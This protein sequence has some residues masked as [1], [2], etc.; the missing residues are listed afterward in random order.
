MASSHARDV[1]D[2]CTGCSLIPGSFCNLSVAARTALSA[3]KFTAIYPPGAV[4]FGEGDLP[5]GVFIL[6]SGRA[7]VATSSTEGKTLIMRIAEPGEILGISAALNG[8]PYEV[9]AETMTPAQLTFIK[10]NDFLRLLQSNAE[11]C[12]NAVRQLSAKYHAAQ[13]EI[14]SLGLAHTTSEKLAHLLLEWC[15]AHGTPTRR[16]TRVQVLYTH[17]QIAQMIG[18]TRETV[19]RVLAELRHG[20]IIEVLGP[21]IV[22]LNRPALEATITT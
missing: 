20:E 12:L 5:R 14:R 4:L 13:R 21:N 19:T 15:D 16:G 17:E 8:K 2:D 6:C 22:V 3:V 11:L 7:K 9:S 18:S 10:R 1:Y